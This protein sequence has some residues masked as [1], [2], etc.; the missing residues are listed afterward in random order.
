MQSCWGQGVDL[1]LEKLQWLED[2]VNEIRVAW[3]EAAQEAE[4]SDVELVAELLEHLSCIKTRQ[5]Q[6]KQK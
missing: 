5:L 4:M 3:E 1:E 2:Q 6:F